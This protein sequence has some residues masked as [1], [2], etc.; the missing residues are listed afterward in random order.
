MGAN[1][2]SDVYNWDEGINNRE[3]GEGARGNNKVTIVSCQYCC[4]I[5]QGPNQE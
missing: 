4:L 1:V 2:V 3:W 5:I